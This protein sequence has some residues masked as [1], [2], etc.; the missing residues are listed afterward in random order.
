MEDLV[1]YSER[2]LGKKVCL[3]LGVL[4]RPPH[5]HRDS[6]R[7]VRQ[8]RQLERLYVLPQLPNCGKV[9]PLAELA[10]LPLP[11]AELPLPLAESQEVDLLAL[12][13]L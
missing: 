3:A 4:P 12:S 8:V 1:Q 10:E 13:L 6:V 9:V 2:S 7:Q 11:L 5:S